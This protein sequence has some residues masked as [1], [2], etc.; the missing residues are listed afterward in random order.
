M[1]RG[2]C[3][4]LLCSKSRCSR[5]LQCL[6]LGGMR[7]K[8][9]SKSFI[10]SILLP[11][12]N[13]ILLSPH[14]SMMTVRRLSDASSFLSIFL[15]F[16]FEMIRVPPC[17]ITA[18][19]AIHDDSKAT[20]NNKSGSIFFIT[21]LLLHKGNLLNSYVVFEIIEVYNDNV[22][23]YD[24]AVWWLGLSKVTTIR[25]FRLDDTFACL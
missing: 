11:F 10:D 5:F 12:G 18:S 17:C 22:V 2:M 3:L 15:M 9:L 8:S 6:M 21:T 1:K 23:F 19:C 7:F 4:I 16:W 24:E 20:V 13:L 14:F 25:I